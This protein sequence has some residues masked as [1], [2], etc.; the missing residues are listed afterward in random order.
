MYR[1]TRYSGGTAVTPGRRARHGLGHDQRQRPERIRRNFRSAP[2]G[3]LREARPLS[4]GSCAVGN[5]QVGCAE[6]VLKRRRTWRAWRAL[7]ASGS[8]P[9]VLRRIRFC[10]K[11][12]PP[13][14]LWKGVARRL[15]TRRS[16]VQILPPLPSLVA[17]KRG[18]CDHTA[19]PVCRPDDARQVAKEQL[20]RFESGLL[21]NYDAKP[22]QRSR[23][24][25]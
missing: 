20:R 13:L 24:W 19:S 15:I 5:C 10:S 1:A 8:G 6:N 18:T 7:T 23:G 2:H 3:P 9:K 16:Q 17:C 25:A 22:V 11:L 12:V 21:G 14:G 4:A